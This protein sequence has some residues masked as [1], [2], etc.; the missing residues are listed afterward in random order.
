[1]RG[2]RFAS[3]RGHSGLVGNLP[4][5]YNLA[6]LPHVPS[7]V[8]SS[9]SL[10][11]TGLLLITYPWLSRI[12]VVWPGFGWETEGERILGKRHAAHALANASSNE[13]TSLLPNCHHCCCSK[14]T[15]WCKRSNVSLS[16]C[17]SLPLSLSLSL[18][19]SLSLSVPP[20]ATVSRMCLQALRILRCLH[21]EII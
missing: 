21:R 2:G 12:R 17:L 14:A 16:L 3:F 8:T 10:I 5:G 18:S 13:P 7:N 19:P 11:Y 15:G 1:M 20:Q 4:S 6:S 9:L